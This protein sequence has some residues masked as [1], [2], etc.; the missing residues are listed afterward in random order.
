MWA[1]SLWDFYSQKS[2]ILEYLSFLPT[3]HKPFSHFGHNP[4]IL[5]ESMKSEWVTDWMKEKR[6]D[7]T[8]QLCPEE[9]QS[10]AVS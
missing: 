10:F 5:N 2:R 3:H 1:S 9:L 7:E 6:R 4:M 8:E